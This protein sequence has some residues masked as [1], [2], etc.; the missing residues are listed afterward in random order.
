[1]ESY[2]TYKKPSV[3]FSFKRFDYISYSYYCSDCLGKHKFEKKKYLV[4][5]YCISSHLTY[6]T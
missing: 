6:L 3:F 1:M 4:G 5:N 2:S